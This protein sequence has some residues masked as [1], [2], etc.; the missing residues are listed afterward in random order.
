M[1]EKRLRRR[2]VT[3]RRATLA[4]ILLAS[5]ATADNGA[6]VTQSDAV[7]SAKEFSLNLPPLPLH[8]A[9]IKEVT[10]HPFLGET[11]TQSIENF[12][13]NHTNVRIIKDLIN[14]LN[15]EGK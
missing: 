10:D 15:K 14:K 1:R 2:S 4:A 3:V 9:S 6:P 7:S 12:F 13:L 5:S 8:S 11:Q